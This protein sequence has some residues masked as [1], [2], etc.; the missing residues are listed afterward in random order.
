MSTSRGSRHAG[1]SH[2]NHPTDSNLFSFSEE[3]LAP[4]VAA[5]AEATPLAKRV[6]HSPRQIQIPPIDVPDVL[7]DIADDINQPDVVQSLASE[8]LVDQVSFVNSLF[9][10]QGSL[11][12]SQVA[13]AS[14]VIYSVYSAGGALVSASAN[15]AYPSL[16]SEFSSGFLGGEFHFQKIGLRKGGAR[17]SPSTDGIPVF[18][19]FFLPRCLFTLRRSR[20]FNCCRAR[21]VSLSK[22]DE[23]FVILASSLTRVIA[24]FH[25]QVVE[26]AFKRL[27]QRTEAVLLL[28]QPPELPVP[29]PLPFHRLLLQTTPTEQCYPAF[30]VDWLRSSSDQ[31]LSSLL[32]PSYKAKDLIFKIPSFCVRFCCPYLSHSSPT[33]PARSL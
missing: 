7:G 15:P 19:P 16:A 4:Q 20:C 28:L 6:P 2:Q 1:K 13:S 11:D 10:G 24:L 22:L 18:D 5:R 3:N 23:M 12:A 21:Q 33:Q 29:L 32:G 25:S 27:Q 14:A 30:Q 17:K 26:P 8:E 9:Q 31:S